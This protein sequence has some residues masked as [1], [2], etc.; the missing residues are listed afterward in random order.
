MIGIN[1]ERESRESVQFARLDDDDSYNDDDDDGEEKVKKK[2]ELYKMNLQKYSYRYM[3][4]AKMH[5][6]LYIPH[7]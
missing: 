6:L 2:E 5:V 4:P 7:I 3:I 1:G